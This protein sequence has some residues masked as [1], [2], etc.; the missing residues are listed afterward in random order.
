MVSTR[1]QRT[2]WSEEAEMR[3][4]VLALPAGESDHLNEVSV[5]HP[6]RIELLGEELELSATALRVPGAEHRRH[7]RGSIAARVSARILQQPR[8]V[9]QDLPSIGTPIDGAIDQVVVWLTVVGEGRPEDLGDRLVPLNRD[10]GVSLFEEVTVR[11]EQREL[12][13][14]ELGCRRKE[15]IE[16]RVEPVDD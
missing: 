3:C 12:K 11:R 2:T 4:H 16:G 1:T 9:Q 8:C 14:P 13:G 15:V 6:C 5:V 7:P 10:V